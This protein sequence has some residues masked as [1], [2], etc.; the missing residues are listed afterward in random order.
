MAKKVKMDKI[1]PGPA[2]TGC[3]SVNDL[4]TTPNITEKYG[5][6]SAKYTS[7]AQAPLSQLE[8]WLMARAAFTHPEAYKSILSSLENV[9]HCYECLGAVFRREC[10]ADPSFLWKVI[11]WDR[12]QV[13]HLSRWIGKIQWSSLGQPPEYGF[14]P[15][16]TM[17]WPD[18]IEAAERA[19]YVFFQPKVPTPVVPAEKS[20]A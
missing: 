3:P 15:G 12:V 9:Q 4:L 7:I 19:G 17:N 20:A 18:W 5:S 13:V 2:E 10:K 6:Y 1:Q 11:E 8:A 16:H 14:I